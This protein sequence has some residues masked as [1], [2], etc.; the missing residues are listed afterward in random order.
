MEPYDSF[1]KCKRELSRKRK[2]AKEA[3]N[4]SKLKKHQDE[5]KLANWAYQYLQE[6]MRK[7]E[8]KQ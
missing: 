1:L 7:E 5:Y 6:F 3:Y 4:M 8:I 2:A